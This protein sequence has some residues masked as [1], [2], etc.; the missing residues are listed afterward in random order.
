VVVGVRGYVVD[1]PV[2]D[3]VEREAAYVATKAP[4]E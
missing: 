4:D 1:H 2:T 3:K